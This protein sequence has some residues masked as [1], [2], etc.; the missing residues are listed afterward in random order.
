MFQRVFVF[1]TFLTFFFSVFSCAQELPR[2]SFMGIRVVPAP[3]SLARALGAVPGAPLVQGLVPHASAAELGIKQGD[4]LQTI[5]GAALPDVQSFL[6]V[7]R[8]LR[9]GD[10]LAVSLLRK[11]REQILRGELGAQPLEE[12]PHA[13][14]QYAVVAYKDGLLRSIVSKPKKMEG[15]KAP[16]VF[17]IPGY[18]CASIDNLPPT[19]PYRQLFERFQEAGFAL[20]RI[21]KPGMGDCQGFDCQ[22]IDF[23]TEADAFAAGYE[24]MLKN[25]DFIDTSRIFIFGHSLGGLTAPLIAERYNPRG[26]VVYGTVLKP[27]HDYFIDILRKQTPML[28]GD[29]A[30]AQRQLEEVY[31]PLLYDFFYRGMSPQELAS[32]SEAEAQALREV[33]QFDGKDQITQRHYTFWQTLNKVNF[34]AAWQKQRAKV[35]SI[36]GEADLA[37]IDEMSAKEI[38]ALVNSQRPG[39][40]TFYLCPKTNHSMQVVGTKAEW[41]ARR[42]DRSAPRPVFNEDFVE[43]VCSW[44]KR[45]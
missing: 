30:G 14:F 19:H 34:A 22:Q 17:F 16:V 38:T 10:E 18:T 2:R 32:R 3:D 39:D 33:F 37:A 26:V 11:G 31:R 24:D 7:I 12:S 41:I 6:R 4:I 35:L 40:A 9:A 28:T 42:L 25:Y 43:Y 13:T 27:W 36:Y 21:E 23:P 8:K 45:Q 20:Y 29:Y 44:M 1:L 15:E 5:N